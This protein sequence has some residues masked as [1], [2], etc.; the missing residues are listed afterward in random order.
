MWRDQCYLSGNRQTLDISQFICKL[1]GKT[2]GTKNL[3]QHTRTCGGECYLYVNSVR[4]QSQE[5]GFL[6]NNLK[7]FKP[8]SKYVSCRKKFTLKLNCINIIFTCNELYK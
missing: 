4:N 1:C 8:L 6:K 3:Q 2:F 5:A 7:S